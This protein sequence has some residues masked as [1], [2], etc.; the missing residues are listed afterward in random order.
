M[1]NLTNITEYQLLAPGYDA[2]IE[3]GTGKDILLLP[4]DI[5]IVGIDI[6]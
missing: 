4:E 2:I 5:N 3:I 6:R 1:N